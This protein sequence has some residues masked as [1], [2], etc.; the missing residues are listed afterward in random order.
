MKSGMRATWLLFFTLSF[1]GQASV[2]AQLAEINKPAS[3]D[4]A[5]LTFLDAV[6]IV[7][8]N[9]LLL[10][11]QRNQLELNQ[12]YKNSSIASLLPSVSISG[13]ATRSDGN[14]FN[15]NQGRVVNGVQD[16]LRGSIDANMTLFNGF[17]NLNTIR[18]YTT[19]L[20]AQSYFV[21]RTAQDAINTVGTQY[22][23]VLLDLELVRIA[24]DNLDV[25][26]NQLR[27]VKAFVEA[28]ARSQVDEYNQDAL[29]RAAELRYVQAKVTLNNDQAMLTQ[30]LLIDP[31]DEFKVQK[32]SWNLDAITMDKMDM[33]TLLNT[34]MQY[35]S[36]YQRAVKL[37]ASQK[38]AARAARSGYLPSLTAFAGY[39]S[40]YNFQRNLPDSVLQQDPSI[41]RPFNQ[42]VREDNVYKNYGLRLTIPVF[43]GLQN[44]ANYV[45]QR[46]LSD[47]AILNKQNVEFQLRNDVRR[48]AVNFEGI[49]QAY[50]I[51]L[52]RLRAAELAFQFETERYNLGI[53]SIVEYTTANNA[54]IQALTDK[55]QAEYR[56]L[57]QKI[58]LEYTLGTLKVEDLE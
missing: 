58:Q 37:E 15:Q 49:R 1:F 41:N 2:H 3:G 36:D 46:V 54:Y 7:L 35:R 29:T 44:R 26:E 25:Q 32:P 40:S 55:A 43:N 8:R 21:N 5:V 42:Q 33:T 47:N 9:G 28:G 22:L 27:Q 45:Q 12:V 4:T 53:T 18:Q 6:K 48:T 57:F 11:Q 24:K 50:Q 31:F 38:F 34:A 39:G 51:S 56:L 19:A 13:G 23:Q 14:S 20:D 16:N 10:N 30:T 52:T 17:Y